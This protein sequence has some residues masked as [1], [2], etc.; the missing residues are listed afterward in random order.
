MTL[1]TP[2]MSRDDSF[3]SLVCR[4]VVTEVTLKIERETLVTVRKKDLKLV[5]FEYL[6][7]VK[8]FLQ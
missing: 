7:A 6:Q 3:M 4:K 1:L 5:H 8:L 2:G